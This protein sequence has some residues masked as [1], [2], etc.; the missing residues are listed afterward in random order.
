MVD[1]SLQRQAQRALEWDHLLQALA[2][3]AQS[4]MGAEY[5]RQLPLET[6]LEDARIRQQE[7]TEMRMVL[8]RATPIPVL[9][10]EDMRDVFERVSK[11]AQLEGLE[12]FHVSVMLGLCHD[13]ADA[14]EG[15]EESCP[16]IHGLAQEL[17]P[18][19]WVYEA[20]VRCVDH[21]GHIQ[22][23]ATPE[24]HDLLQHLH[25]LRQRI[26]QRLERL[27]ASHEHEEL[28][29]GQYFAERENRYVIPVKADMQHQMPGIV[30][31]ISG[32]GATVFLEPRDFIEL[33][34]AIKIADLQVKQ[35]VARILQDLSG[36]V[37]THVTALSQ[38]LERL[39]RLDSLAA[40]ARL[41]LAMRAN[42]IALH[43]RQQIVL[44]QAR[45][46]LLVLKKDHVVPNDFHLT[47]ENNIYIISGPNTGGKTVTLKLVGLY[48]LMARAGLHLPCQEHS[49]MG[50]FQRIFADIGDA[51]DIQHDLSS[52]SAHI[53]NMIALLQ[54]TR[55]H[56][57]DDCSAS[58]VLLDEI[59]NATDPVEG[60]ALAEA[61]L[62]HLDESGFKVIVTTH[63]HSLKTLP[64]RRAGFV[65]ASHE[66]NLTTLSPTYRLLEGLPGGSSAIEIAGK[67][68]LRQKI[69][70]HASA[71]M[72]GQERDLESVFQ[73]LQ[74]TRQQLNHELQQ[75][76]VLRL[77]AEQ[78][79]QEAREAKDR[80]RVSERHERQ[81]I[82][83][84]L[85]AE[86]SRLTRTINEA[87]EELKR[88]KTLSKTQSIRR[89]VSAL[90]Q[91][92]QALFA[93]EETMP[94]HLAKVG[95]VVEIKNLGTTGILL[96]PAQEK[97]RVKIRI[98]EKVVS[99]EA[100]LL[101]RIGSSHVSQ[102]VSSS[103]KASPGRSKQQKSALP[104][105][106][107][108]HATQ[109]A[110]PSFK[111]DVRGKAVDEALEVTESACDHA[112]QRGLSSMLVLHGHGTGKLKASLRAY[113]ASS[114]YVAG[115][116]PGERSEGGDGVTIVALR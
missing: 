8:E 25:Q 9:A 45:H 111:I 91:D 104:A 6:S 75:T 60:A 90:Q 7:T 21:E 99:I 26:R 65:N 112:M 62:C 95:D 5:C 17:E 63:Y 71:L 80:V 92:S 110:L 61:L 98:G 81:K 100:N 83:K 105:V 11:G 106:S 33:N 14:L 38:N 73:Q 59:G 89:R 109:I 86:F 10:F 54:E 43:E 108:V 94:L 87:I 23:T 18:L 46:P 66:F 74:D 102:G 3:H 51:Q 30:H 85:H 19:A 50:L 79:H 27:L 48:A 115:F 44:K 58:L 56:S 28:L 77:E 2:A 72:Q 29:Q 12:L 36:M 113:F 49:E 41:S 68:G 64:L 42:P 70:T 31:D 97:A 82:R 53:T 22:D 67:L 93:Q 88:D 76:Q 57:S 32:S 101:Q 52:F 24:L 15:Y 20:I 16:L 114:A 13:L 84:A 34:N 1:D 47:D 4:S 78:F 69:L 96:E 55:A 40:K 35:E 116:R 107:H 37:A 103:S 39:Q